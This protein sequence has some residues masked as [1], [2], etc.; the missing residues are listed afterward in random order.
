MIFKRFYTNEKVLEQ[1]D[2][3]FRHGVSARY[4][5]IFDNPFETFE[6]SLESIKL[7]L[8]F[9]QPFSINPF[10]LK[11]FP[12]TGITSMA[13]LEGIITQQSVDDECLYSQ[14]TYLVSGNRGTQNQQFINNLAIYVNSQAS[15]GLLNSDF[16][17]QIIMRFATSKDL[18]EI[19][20]LVEESWHV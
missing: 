6:E 20:E 15:L 19:Q 2:I 16:V 10:S 17:E 11:Y 9:P 5:F 13:L 1:A 3:F 12:N 8:Q 18:K 4:D 14:D 7:M